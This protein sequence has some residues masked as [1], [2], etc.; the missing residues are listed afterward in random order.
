[1][2]KRRPAVGALTLTLGAAAFLAIASNLAFWRTLGALAPPDSPGGAGFLAATFVILVVLLNLIFL[3]FAFRFVLK[4]VLIGA[5][6]IAA[7]CAHFMGAYGV[8][9]DRDM[10]QNVA[11]T[12]PRE[13]RDLLTSGLVLH[14]LL[15][16]ALPAAGVA[17]LPLRFGSLRR[18][19]VTRLAVT[20]VSVVLAG[21]LVA[22]H[23][24]EFSLIGRQHGELRLLINP[25]SPIYAALRF[26]RGSSEPQS[27]L[28][29]AADARRSSPAKGRK[30]LVVLV[31]GETARAAS[32]S[33]NGYA[34]DTNPLLSR[35]PVVNFTQVSSCGTSTAVSVPCM[36]GALGRAEYSDHE[37]KRR[38]SLLDVL[39]RVGVNV[40]WR[41][42]NSGCK[43]TCDR[44]PR[45]AGTEL[46]KPVFCDGDGCFDEVLLEGL[47]A[48][49][50]RL[51]G[52]GLVVLHQ[53]GS[54]GPAYWKR[55]PEAF[56]RFLPECHDAAVESCSRE[57]IVNAYDNT[58]LYTDFVLSRLIDLLARNAERVDTAMLYVSDH[59]ES[60]GEHGI[61]LHGLPWRLA[62]DEQTRVPMLAWLSD[63]FA[64]SRAIDVECLERRRH[65]P[66]SHDHLF[67]SMLGLFAVE[68][69]A[70]SPALDLFG[71]CRGPRVAHRASAIGTAAKPRTLVE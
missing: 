69:R 10:I 68:T 57:A 54:H 2:L 16:G 15:L 34:R 36:F 20:G 52:D 40:L 31:V 37:A 18:E 27:A 5:L 1:V 47:Q 41:D 39:Q 8:V 26:L 30:T 67:H 23:F 19:L 44:V 32:F 70:Y 29:I 63:G 48:Y 25:T 3:L 46:R 6:L 7:V 38:E 35:Q 66:V 51:D 28:A 42:N 58:I 61:Y 4:P 56:K 24:K 22:L 49:I 50:D 71:P 9:I 65:E 21:A 64:E 53:Q 17:L 55:S 13:V 43:S 12:D 59:G 14:V 60:L 45:Q 11:E 33:L 62:P